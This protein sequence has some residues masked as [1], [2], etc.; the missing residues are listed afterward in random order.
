M[1]APGNISSQKAMIP[2][3]LPTVPLYIDFRSK[4][5]IGAQTKSENSPI[6]GM[7]NDNI[8]IASNNKPHKS[9]RYFERSL[10][11]RSEEH[12]SELQSRENLVCRLQPT[13]SPAIHTLSLTTLF[14]SRR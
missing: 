2:P 1:S 10:V 4:P 13:P 9:S 11:F 8:P 7:L 3:T 5:A 14:R 6:K 12:T